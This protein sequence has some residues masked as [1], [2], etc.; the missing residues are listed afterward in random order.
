MLAHIC[1]FLLWVDSQHSHDHKWYNLNN[2]LCCFPKEDSLPQVISFAT[3]PKLVYECV[4][5]QLMSVFIWVSEQ[6]L[7]KFFT[8]ACLRVCV[9]NNVIQNNS[10]TP[11]LAL[12]LWLGDGR[13][14]RSNQG[15]ICSSD[16][17][18]R[19]GRRVFVLLWFSRCTKIWKSKRT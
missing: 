10:S 18:T 5:M 16:G 1:I 19:K 3:R 7:S 14:E 2:R 6:N 13:D 15:C 4:C 12:L 11:P 8:L 9:V 17:K